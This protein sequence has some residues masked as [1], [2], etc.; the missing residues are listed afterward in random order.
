MEMLRTDQVLPWQL[1]A[2]LRNYKK[3]KYV[4]IVFKLKT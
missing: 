2:A 4:P 3:S 1:N